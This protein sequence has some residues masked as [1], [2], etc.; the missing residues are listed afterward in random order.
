MCLNS[1]KR[2]FAIIIICLFIGTL[3]GAPSSFMANL[4]SLQGKNVQSFTV[5]Q[6]FLEDSKTDV[7]EGNT[8]ACAPAYAVYGASVNAKITLLNEASVVRFILVDKFGN[9]YMIYEINSLLAEGN[10]FSI[11]DACHETKLLNAVTPV[12]VR[13]DLLAATA[14]FQRVSFAAEAPISRSEISALQEQIKADQ[15]VQRIALYNKMIKLKG[16]EWIAGPTEISMKSYQE[17]KCYYLGGEANPLPNT[18][19]TEFYAGGVMPGRTN[20]PPVNLKMPK[21]SMFVDTFDW[22]NRHGATSSSSPYYN[23]ASNG[24]Y[25]GWASK[26]ENQGSCGSCYIFASTGEG[27]TKFNLY[28]NDHTGVR[29][30]EQY[31]GACSDRYAGRMCNGG[32]PYRVSDFMVDE[33]ILDEESFRYT[34]SNSTPCRDSADN[35]N[36]HC[37]FDSYKSLKNNEVEDWEDL[38]MA[39]IKYGPNAGADLSISHAMTVVG[40]IY[41][42]G[43]MTI[44]YKNSHGQNSG[45]NGYMY[46]KSPWSQS[47]WAVFDMTVPEAIRSEIYS[48]EDIRCVDLDNDGY[49]NW[50]IGPK[51]ATCPDN[52]PDEVDCDDSDP[53]FGPYIEE[54]G[55]WTGECGE[56]VVAIVP[57]KSTF[58]GISYRCLYDPVRKASVIKFETPN[59]AIASAKIY[60]M[61]GSLVKTLSVSKQEDGMQKAVW[62]RSG[63]PVSKGIYVCT[64]SIENAGDVTKTS[65]KIPVLR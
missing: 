49:Y 27:E 58:S 53:E 50:G 26:I 25:N 8:V 32:M 14:D 44:I 42:N 22:R 65:F 28:Y 41:R 11:A 4:F 24:R 60:G 33:G 63:S 16:E 51:P 30:S 2:F 34:A 15:H 36:D 40:Y 35:P 5:N 47:S 43:D 45:Q 56:I 54:N 9:E 62:D 37:Y 20:T 39:I 52:C 7:V 59:N 3:Y 57:A 55:V 48:D 61:S 23:D 1:I 31:V 12:S 29:L 19:G 38:K 17:K 18:Q 6:T 46:R 21:V 13:V 10:S 64:I